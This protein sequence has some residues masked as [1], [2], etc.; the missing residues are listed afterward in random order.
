MDHDE[1]KLHGE[2][3]ARCVALF[4]E[5]AA[6]PPAGLSREVFLKL[7]MQATVCRWT[8]LPMSRAERDNYIKAIIITLSDLDPANALE[9]MLAVQMITNHEVI[10]A[11][12]SRALN[13]GE[14]PLH[15]DATQKHAIKAMETSM[16]QMVAYQRL[17]SQ[18]QVT[19]K[20]IQPRTNPPPAL[21][22]RSMDKDPGIE[23]VDR[24]PVRKGS[25]K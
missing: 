14:L 19:M 21:A 15:R 16:K 13:Q 18:R 3:Y 7:V 11:C 9:G 20:R 12:H 5:I 22:D 10:V 1:M 2:A 8:A 6:E 23:T 4:D 17:T 24:T 25:G